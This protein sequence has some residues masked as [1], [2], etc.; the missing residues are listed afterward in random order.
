MA[1]EL[2]NYLKKPVFISCL[3]CIFVFYSGI[4]HIP[5][6]N[7]FCSLLQENQIRCIGGTIVSSPVKTG[8]G[9][10]Y[11]A[12][13]KADLAEDSRNFSSSAKGNLQI[14]IP[15]EKVEAL[16]PGKIF[17]LSRNKF[18]YEKG[19]DCVLYGK[20]NS[21]GFYV[22]NLKSGSW[23]I[24]F[25]G[26]I[27]YIRALC[28]LHFARLMY[29][30]GSAGG[31]LLALLS[32]AREYTD[33]AVQDSFRKAG[34]S[35]ILAL[36]GMHLS[37]FSAIAVFFGNKAGIKKLTFILR[38]FALIAFVWFA[39]FSPSLLRAFICTMLTIVAAIAG[40][41]QSD[42]L[43][44]LS[45]SFLL[46]SA[47]SPADIHSTGFILS[48]GA[49]AGILVWGKV[50]TRLY[51]KLFPRAFALSL[52]SSTAAQTFT[53]PVSLKVFGSCS[54]IGIISATV[55]SPFITIFIYSGL[56]LIIL[57]LIFPLLSKPSGIFI[58][59][60]YTVINY[61]VKLF[62]LVPDWSIN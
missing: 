12:V 40:A 38:I 53:I 26:K 21:N 10:Y 4:F 37:M 39:G 62:S 30:W 7:K 61:L 28:R 3:I 13:L 60:Q 54:P 19:A 15:S 14:F 27:K 17:S 36:S 46:Q 51:S 24:S 49:L 48:Y 1:V 50:F 41:K 25:T 31:L 47:I 35:H 58:N 18:I 9:K 32:G 29:G 45:F 42:M 33:K 34:L 20:F 8:N 5:E 55:V 44:I 16:Y 57:S 6:K 2:F 11:S 22:S 52:S 23:P 59:L 56:L 43:S